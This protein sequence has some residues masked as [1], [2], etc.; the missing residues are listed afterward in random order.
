MS[1]IDDEL[2][3]WL[4]RVQAKTEEINNAVDQGL[5]KS[6]L[7]CEGQAKQTAN[8]IFTNNP[9]VNE[10]GEE[11]WEHTGLL[12]ASIGSGMNP[13]LTHSAMIYC[14]ASY[15]KYLEYG[16]GIYAVNGDGRQT[17]WCYVSNTGVLNFTQG[18]RAKPFMYPSVFNSQDQ[19]QSI[20][21][22]YVAKAVV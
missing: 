13:E 8:S 1:E 11:M 9:P 14:S 16:T 21:L 3:D 19:I 15:A 4:N 10:K 12:E 22:S 5:L 17:P 7:Y 6:A 2:N 18:M 20:I